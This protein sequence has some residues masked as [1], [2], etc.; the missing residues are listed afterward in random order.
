MK[1]FIGV[2]ELMVSRQLA[3]IVE[4]LVHDEV[5]HN[6]HRLFRHAPARH[7]RASCS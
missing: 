1:R 4:Q 2:P 7:G 5:A 3:V 6:V